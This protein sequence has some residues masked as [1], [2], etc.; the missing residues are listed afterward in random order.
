MNL[1]PGSVSIESAPHSHNHDACR[2]KAVQ[3]ADKLC[4]ERGVQL[5]PIRLKVLE[6]I[7]ASHQAVK[8]YDLLDQMKP[9]LQSAKPATIYRALDFCWNKGLYIGWKAL[10]PLWV[11]VVPRRITRCCCLFVY[12]AMK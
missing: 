11:A 6:L 12:S 5:T 9:L 4:R 7:S 2:N 3:T 10:M 1:I 8:A